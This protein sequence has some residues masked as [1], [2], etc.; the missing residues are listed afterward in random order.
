MQEANELVVQAAEKQPKKGRSREE[1]I[2]RLKYII[3][4]QTP[5]VPTL[6]N[7]HRYSIQDLFTMLLAIRSNEP[8]Y[9]PLAG[10]P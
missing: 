10:N 9:P 2:G 3:I 1:K 8:C 6:V 5:V 7:M 4:Q